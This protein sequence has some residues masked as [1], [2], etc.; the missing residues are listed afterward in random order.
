MKV[1]RELLTISRRSH[2]LIEH[3]SHLI[4]RRHI[5]YEVVFAI[6]C[7]YVCLFVC[8]WFKRKAFDA[9]DLKLASVFRLTSRNIFVQ[10]NKMFA[11][12]RSKSQRGRWTWWLWLRSSSNNNN[13]SCSSSEKWWR[14]RRGRNSAIW[15]KFQARRNSRSNWILSV[16]WIWE[17]SKSS[18]SKL[19]CWL[20]IF[21]LTTDYVCVCVFVS[22]WI[23]IPLNLSY[24]HHGIFAAQDCVVCVVSIFSLSF[25]L[26]ARCCCC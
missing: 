16:D 25:S 15:H 1:Q 11:C 12:E 7:G 5:L 23:F 3:S 20:E 2:E 13:S 24:L 6:A 9:I 17:L 21:H 26:V 8:V 14:R 22:F 19:I 4:R 10:N 18:M